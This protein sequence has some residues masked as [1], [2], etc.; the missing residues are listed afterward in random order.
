MATGRTTLIPLSGSQKAVCQ[1]RAVRG[2]LG[3]PQL[4]VRAAE[5]QSWTRS[6]VN[7]PC[8]AAALGKVLPALMNWYEL[9]WCLLGWNAE[10][11]WRGRER[12]QPQ[13]FGKRLCGGERRWLE[14]VSQKLQAPQ[15]SHCQPL[16]CF[17]QPDCT[18]R[19]WEWML[20]PETL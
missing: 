6:P 19:G 14:L 3:K 10:S 16:V 2:V 20:K 12:R 7:S 15:D 18:T 5:Q 8:S 17:W 1:G 11:Q 13:C 4:G 9:C